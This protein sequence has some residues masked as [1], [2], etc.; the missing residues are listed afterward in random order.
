MGKVNL[1]VFRREAT[2]AFNTKLVRDIAMDGA[3][4]AL[5]RAKAIAIKEF[6]NHP[7]TRELRS[8]GQMKIISLAPEVL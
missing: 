5:D 2:K 4:K 3:N 1:N 6:N 7:V 8:K